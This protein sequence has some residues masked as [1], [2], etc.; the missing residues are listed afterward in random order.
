MATDLFG[1]YFNNPTKSYIYANLICANA[2]SGDELSFD[3]TNSEGTISNNN[4]VLSK[5][6]L[7]DVHVGL[8]EYTND[9]KIIDPHSFIYVKG[10][11]R[12][13]AYCKKY[14]GIV[15]SRILED[16]EWMYK[17]TL[18]FHIKYVD[19]FGNKVAKCIKA[20]GSLE[21]DYTF[22]E[23]CQELF[24]ENKINI[25][26]T[27]EDGYIVFTGGELGYDFWIPMLE[28]WLY[29][30]EGDIQNV[31][32]ELFGDKDPEQTNELGF[33]FDDEWTNATSNT[34]TGTISLGSGNAYTTIISE[35]Q[36]RY[37][38][39]SL[40]ANNVSDDSGDYDIIDVS[41]NELFSMYLFEDLTKY[42][43]AMK[44]RNGA[45]KGVVI[46]ATYPIYNAETIS[47]TQRA[48]KIGFLKDRV[49]EYY[50]TKDNEYMG[51]PLYVRVIKDVVDAYHT[52]YEYDLYKKWSNNYTHINY[53]DNWIDPEEIPYYDSLHSDW[54]HSHVP[55]IYMMNSLYKDVA[56]YDAMG[57]FG[58]ATYL[59][60]HNEWETFGQL[61]ARTTVDDDESL[62]TRN[63]I[64]SFLIYNPNDFPVTVKYMTFV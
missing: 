30:G 27:Y 16:D 33:G 11:S 14:F 6:D 57:L 62:D 48:L 13:L 28:L 64:P 42:V 63:L 54:N 3:I 25:V 2:A 9:M 61:Y 46:N 47:D 21:N 29:T 34:R 45:M 40:G 12:G 43:P 19:K 8:S 49:E 41:T 36:Y 4:D 7:A 10:I 50:T 39:D 17:T 38:Y 35:S 26:I 24:D 44:Y 32:P 23:K 22:I 52:Q 55:N 18:I 51:L 5:I 37:L 53:H 20:S 56:H 58:Y 31:F 59:S 60:K 15:T 1:K